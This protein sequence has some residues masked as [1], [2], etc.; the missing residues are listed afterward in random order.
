MLENNLQNTNQIT[1]NTNPLSVISQ[2]LVLADEQRKSWQELTVV[3][4]LI[5]CRSAPLLH[6]SEIDV[7]AEKRCVGSILFHHA[8]TKMLNRSPKLRV[9]NIEVGKPVQMTVSEAQ[10][11]ELLQ[12]CR[13]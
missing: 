4:D 8:E 12:S 1:L 9:L 3:G 13:H 11:R 6:T 7:E 2:V 5:N 10:L